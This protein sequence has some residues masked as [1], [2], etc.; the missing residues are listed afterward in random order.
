MFNAHE[1][2]SVM[3]RADRDVHGKP[4]L[5]LLT[6]ELI[7]EELG[8]KNWRMQQVIKSIFDFIHGA[9]NAAMISREM[10]KWASEHPLVPGSVLEDV[11]TS[12]IALLSETARAMQFGAVKYG[13][14]NWKNGLPY[15]ETCDAMLRHATKLLYGESTDEESGVGHWGHIMFGVQ[16]LMYMEDNP[17]LKERFD[18]RQLSV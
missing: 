13:R 14:N 15:I 8:L 17:E 18:D 5:S 6:Y 11:N 4:Q 12:S 1:R 7:V 3:T 10:H 2:D 16:V 9:G